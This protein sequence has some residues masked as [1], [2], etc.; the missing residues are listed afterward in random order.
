M[1][2]DAHRF[3][4]LFREYGPIRVRKFFGGEAI[5]DGKAM[6]ALVWDETLYF[7]TSEATRP[8][9]DAE[10]CSPFTFQRGKRIVETSWFAIPGRLYDDP[11]ELADW[12]RS[13]R[14]AALL[15]AARK[16]RAPGKAAR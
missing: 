5:W 4:D 14:D 2:G 8:A 9:Y 12:A 7:T 16:K 15:K 3:D 1:P 6:I 11:A 10:A 13:A